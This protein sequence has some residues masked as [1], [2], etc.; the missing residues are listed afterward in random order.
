MTPFRRPHH[1]TKFYGIPGHETTFLRIDVGRFSGI[2]YGNCEL[3]SGEQVLL[4][5]GFNKLSLV[6]S[7]AFATHRHLVKASLYL[8]L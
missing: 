2:F 1:P 5:I 7:Y 3:I 8:S 4:E 6:F